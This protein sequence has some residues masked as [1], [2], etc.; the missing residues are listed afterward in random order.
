MGVYISPEP[1]GGG[2]MQRPQFSQSLPRACRGVSPKDS[3]P[4]APGTILNSVAN[5]RLAQKTGAPGTRQN[6]PPPRPYHY[7]PGL[8]ARELFLSAARGKIFFLDTPFYRT[9]STISS[10]TSITRCAYYGSGKATR[11]D[12]GWQIGQ[13]FR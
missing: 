3:E 11:M 10:I 7:Q 8:D 13:T 4:G 9:R 5:P 6:P 12:D 1:R 2:I